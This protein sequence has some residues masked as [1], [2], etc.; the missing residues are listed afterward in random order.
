MKRA[1]PFILVLFKLLH[2]SCSQKKEPIE[3]AHDT[4]ILEVS[5]SLL[6]NAMYPGLEIITL[7]SLRPYVVYNST[8]NEIDHDSIRSPF[9]A[10]LLDEVT[11]EEEGLSPFANTIQVSNRFSLGDNLYLYLL[12]EDRGYGGHTV[13]STIMVRFEITSRG[14]NILQK[15]DSFPIGGAEWSNFTRDV[16]LLE[17]DENHWMLTGWHSWGGQRSKGVF[18]V[19]KV[20][21]KHREDLVLN[22]KEVDGRDTLV[23]RVYDSGLE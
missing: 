23:Y 10:V 1:L 5:D 4:P 2:L 13:S 14:V 11:R 3:T 17:F 15:E 18:R 22:P 7:D 16:K 9:H 6:L 8:T 20:I 12:H 21:P 19:S